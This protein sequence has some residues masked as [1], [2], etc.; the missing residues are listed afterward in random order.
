[1]PADPTPTD[2]QGH[3]RST[4]IGLWQAWWRAF[5]LKEPLSGDI[6]Q[7]LINPSLLRDNAQ[8]GI[9][10]ISAMRSPDPAL[11][12]QIV[13]EVASYGRQLG[14]LLE[15]VDVLARQQHRDGLNAADQQALTELEDLAQKVA[16]TKATATAERID[17]L[18]ADILELRKDQDKNRAALK[19]LNDALEGT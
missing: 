9:L 16:A 17:R 11:E 7:H 19:R 13:T 18:V 12:R 1:M 4:L 10:N 15:A 5:G 8:W 3:D 2:P 6:F 14:R